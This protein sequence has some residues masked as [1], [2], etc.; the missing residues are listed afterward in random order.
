MREW[1]CVS[2]VMGMRGFVGAL[3]GVV[4]GLAFGSGA[5]AQSAWYVSG[6]LGGTFRQDVSGPVTFFDVQDR[7]VTAPGTSRAVFGTGLSADLAVGYR[8]SSSFRVEAE[9]GYEDFAQTAL[10]PMTT[11]ALFPNLRGQQ[12]SHA[13]GGDD[14][15]LS[16]AVNGFYDFPTVAGR[17]TPYL[18]GGG[19]VVSGRGADTEFISAHGVHFESEGGSGVRGLVQG[20]AGVAVRLSRNLSVVP[21]YRYIHFTGPR[22][23]GESVAK[24]GLRYAF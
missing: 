9:L 12:F 23:D 6:S 1:A 11:S 16:S 15:A 5:S 3:A 20:E 4:A 7:S 18:G 24:L 14:S 21:A 17:F 10:Y 2:G 19:G 8:I 13:S 22:A